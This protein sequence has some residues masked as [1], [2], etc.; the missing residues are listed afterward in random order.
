MSESHHETADLSLDDFR[1]QAAR[2]DDP[3]AHEV[4]AAEESLHQVDPF[5]DPE[6]LEATEAI[7]VDAL[8]AEVA[9]RR[10]VAT[11]AAEHVAETTGGEAAPIE[12]S[13]VDDDEDDVDHEAT[14]VEILDETT[15]SHD[16]AR[17]VGWADDDL[18]APMTTPPDAPRHHGEFVCATCFLVLNEILRSPDDPSSCI[19]CRPASA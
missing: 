2:D 10:V 3:D 18:D 11:E 4:V 15:H 5:V 16:P 7:D 14:I 12:E 17:E 1:S 13:D 9:A 8:V 6:L 19:E